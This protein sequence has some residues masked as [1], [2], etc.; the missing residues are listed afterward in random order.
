MIYKNE[1]EH[2]IIY[3]D[4]IWNPYE[5]Y[6][7]AFPVPASL[8]L[9]CTQE[10]DMPDP[11]L[12]H[13]DIMIE[14]GNQSNIELSTPSLSHNVALTILCMSGG[15]ECRFN[16][17]NNKPIPIDER[18][19]VQTLSWEL[20]SKIILTNPLDTSVHISVTALEVA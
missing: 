17:A 10:G 6:E 16:G 15:V 14:A 20:C 9:T 4:I 5:E 19:F 3:H 2:T 7:T 11:V 12:F 8:G 13:D 1:T 18:G